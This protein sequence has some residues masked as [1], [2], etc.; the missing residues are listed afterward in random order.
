MNDTCF[1]C[2]AEVQ[3]DF[4]HTCP[5]SEPLAGDAMAYISTMP[6]RQSEMQAAREALAAARSTPAEGT[7]NT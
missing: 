5:Q 2:E 1:Y 6:P 7:T 4:D 3:P